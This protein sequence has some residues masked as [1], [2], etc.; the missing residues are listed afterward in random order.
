MIIKEIDFKLIKGK[1]ENKVFT[2]TNADDT[3]YDMIDSTAKCLFYDTSTPTEIECDIDELT[4]KITVPFTA[5]HSANQ[6]IFEYIIEETKITAE[7]IPLVKGNITVS[8]YVPFSESIE[9]YLNSELPANLTLVED[10]RNQRIFYWRRILQNAFYIS[11]ININVET[12]WPTLVN[13]LLA[14]LVV[15][16]ALE[17][18]AR[19]SFIQFMGGS[20]NDP[21]IAGGGGGGVKSVETSPTKVEYY[22]ASAAAKNAFTASAGGLSMFDVLKESLCGLAGYLKVK[23][24]MCK[25][26]YVPIV[27]RYHQNP[28]W[29]YPS[30]D[31]PDTVE[32]QG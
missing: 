20:Y 32:S 19:G 30:L 9:A 29:A 16:D 22:D 4:G 25:G 8:V 17:L 2:L 11:E 15:Y 6:G 18:A 5:T 7:I 1:I 3:I 21:N 28:D 27:P 26:I 10:Y 13:A 31:E 12:A 14:K 24:P 23:V